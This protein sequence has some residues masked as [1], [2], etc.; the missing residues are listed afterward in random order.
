MRATP[1]ASPSCPVIAPI[2]HADDA[3]GTETMGRRSARY[4]P[5]STASAPS[6]TKIRR[7][8]ARR[9]P[10]ATTSET[11][12]LQ[13]REDRLHPLEG[14]AEIRLGVGV[15]EAQVGFAVRA[16][17]RA[18][19]HGDAGLVEDARRDLGRRTARARDVREDV[20]GAAR[21]RAL[22]AAQLVEAVDDQVAARS[23]E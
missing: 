10:S 14:A 18:R 16:E 23:E 9:R 12:T 13:R 8:P 3:R 11:V 6:A 5:A 2:A 20:E 21:E 1:A 4:A 22:H 17:R 19:E 7:T 15:G